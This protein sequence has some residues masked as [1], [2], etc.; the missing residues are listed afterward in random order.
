MSAETGERTNLKKKLKDL[1]TNEEYWLNATERNEMKW[2]VG[3]VQA[4]KEKRT[5]ERKR[6]R[7][8]R[9]KERKRDW[10]ADRQINTETNTD[11]QIDTRADKQTQT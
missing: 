9:E 5:K 11:R 3:G 6:E 4:R 7:K 1:V 2:L 8:K 10:Q